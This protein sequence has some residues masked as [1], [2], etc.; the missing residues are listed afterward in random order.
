VAR[1][2]RSEQL[3]GGDSM[4]LVIAASG[5]VLKIVQLISHGVGLEYGILGLACGFM[6]LDVIML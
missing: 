5:H 4:V 2:F 3:N 1:E 6:V